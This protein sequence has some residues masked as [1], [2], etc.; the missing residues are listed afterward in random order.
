LLVKKPQ[1]NFLEKFYEIFKVSFYNNFNLKYT[2]FTET[3]VLFFPETKNR[4]GERRWVFKF[5]NRSAN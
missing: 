3:L 2:I 1:E 4:F 5:K